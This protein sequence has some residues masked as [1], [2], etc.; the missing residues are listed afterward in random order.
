MVF[1]HEGNDD[2]IPI[3]TSNPAIKITVPDPP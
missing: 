2:P 3:E 1:Y